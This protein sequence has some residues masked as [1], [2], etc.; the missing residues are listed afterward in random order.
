MGVTIGALETR[1]A[2]GMSA[3][4]TLVSA[5]DEDRR[6]KLRDF[7][8]NCRSRLTPRDVGLP[9]TGRRRVTGLRREEIAELVGVSSDWYRWFE[10]GRSIRVSFEFV[11]RVADALLLD[12][13][14]R[15]ALFRLALPE[16][17]A[18]IEP[19][20]QSSSAALLD[21]V[22]SLRKVVRRVLSASSV[23]E[24]L[25][26]VTEAVAERFT[27]AAIVGVYQRV[28]P[29]Q[30]DYPVVFENGRLPRGTEDVHF[31]LRD[32]LTPA[33]VDE[34]MLYG[35]LSAPGEVGT[36]RELLRCPR[37]KEHVY[38]ALKAEGF[39]DADCLVAQVKSGD[40]VEVTMFVAY[41]TERK[42]FSEF[43]RAQLGLLADVA[44]LTTRSSN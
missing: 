25:T 3:A 40:G 30:W 13:D 28:G 18:A 34:S 39:E 14:E 10:S 32:G 42:L 38:S 12:R 41:H 27:D 9:S 2:T 43:D 15:A 8:M 11:S 37:V 23:S 29:G 21:S 17:A 4:E 22:R 44:S 35:V 16:V 20:L 24:I 1:E 5:C 36:L 31:R 33:Q 7:L 19:S 26:S 6:A